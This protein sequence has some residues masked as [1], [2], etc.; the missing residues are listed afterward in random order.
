MLPPPPRAAAAT[1]RHTLLGAVYNIRRRRCRAR[2]L[3][4]HIAHADMLCRYHLR[5]SSLLRLFRRCRYAIDDIEAILPFS[6][7]PP[8]TSLR[9][10]F[11]R[12][13]AAA[14]CCI[15]F[16]GIFYYAA[17][18][19]LFRRPAMPLSLRALRYVYDFTRFSRHALAACHVDAR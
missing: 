11:R 2:A 3:P 14:R 9:L 18:I 7:L 16:D 4:R 8:S 13:F 5:F 19:V 6:R 17:P 1:L 10:R 15:S 12:R